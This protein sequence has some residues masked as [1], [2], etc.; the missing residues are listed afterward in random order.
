MGTRLVTTI[1][2]YLNLYAEPIVTLTRGAFTCT[3]QVFLILYTK[4]G[5]GDSKELAS[6]NNFLKIS[7][8][9]GF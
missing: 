5:M 8:C 6:P 9:L 1:F 4:K 2:M 7:I 3:M